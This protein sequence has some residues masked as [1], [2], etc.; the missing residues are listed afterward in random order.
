MPVMSEEAL[1]LLTE[2]S[3]VIA[4]W[5]VDVPNSRAMARAHNS[6]QW[7]RLT[8]KVYAAGPAEPTDEQELW[9]AALHFGKD[10]L[11]SG[12]AALGVHGWTGQRAGDIDVLVPRKAY[13]RGT[14]QGVAVH[15]TIFMPRASRQGIP[16]AVP[17]SATADAAAWA[18]TTREAE[19]LVVSVL[20]QQLCTPTALEAVLLDRTTTSR[21]SVILATIREFKGGSTTMG[22]LDFARLCRE[23]GIREPD[24]QVWCKVGGKRRRLDCHWDAEGVVAEV[25]GIGHLEFDQYVDDQERQNDVVLTEGC[26]VLRATNLVLRYEP[27]VFMGQLQVALGVEVAA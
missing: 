15:R 11:L 7:R 5:Q 24:R 14:P 18:R 6:G 8:R 26:V 21:R 12:Q 9:A 10:S 16:R 23:Y 2:Q 13:V 19:F 27:E 25:D 3:N 17:E 22:E 20:Q 4:T 1:Q